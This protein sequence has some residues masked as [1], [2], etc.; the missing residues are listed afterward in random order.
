LGAKLASNLP[1]PV[2]KLALSYFEGI[3]AEA[4]ALA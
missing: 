1:V 2:A 3:F 4:A